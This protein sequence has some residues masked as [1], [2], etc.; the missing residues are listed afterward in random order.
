MKLLVF[1]ASTSSTSINRRLLDY[2]T[3]LLADDIEVENIDLNDYEMPIFNVDR[4]NEN[5]I[6]QEAQDF[7][8]KIGAA[9]AVMIS[10][11]E[12]NGSYSAA[13]KN[14]FDWA[15]RIDQRVYQGTPAVLFSTSIGPGGGANV[16]NAAVM[17]GP[18][19]GY[20]V[21][22][23]LAIPSFIQ[24]FDVESGS[25]SDADLDEQFRAALT[26]LND[27]AKAPA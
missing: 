7:F 23:S 26:S 11:A 15:S 27:V 25:L 3:S 13:Y 9:D 18:Y 19:F 16:L 4:Q 24:N 1:A 22:A 10:F 17:S 14:I 12:H 20:E 2:A 21:L 5:G 6:P 8:D